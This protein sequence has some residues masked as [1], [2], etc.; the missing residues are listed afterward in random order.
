MHPCRAVGGVFLCLAVWACGGTRGPPY[1]AQ[2]PSYG[3]SAPSPR[4]QVHESRAW[5]DFNARLQSQGQQPALLDAR[6][7]AAAAALNDLRVQSLARDACDVGPG[8]TE[9]ALEW[10]GVYERPVCQRC[11][12]T[13]KS[14]VR[15]PDDVL[16]GL[17]ECVRSQPAGTALWGAHTRTES[18]RTFVSLLA[19]RRVASLDPVARFGRGAPVEL[20][21]VLPAGTFTLLTAPTQLPAVAA[22]LVP[23]GRGVFRHSV[24]P[25]AAGKNV[26]VTLVDPTGA[27]VA[28]LV[29]E[30]G[31]PR[32]HGA[33]EGML[34]PGD[35]TLP[36]LHQALR[37]SVTAV[38][39]QAGLLP[40][41]WSTVLD[42]AA[43]EEA[44]QAR[45][46]AA[47]HTQPPAP[48]TQTAA[49]S[50]GPAYRVFKVYGLGS[51]DLAR[52]L[53]GNP[54]VVHALTRPVD[55]SVGVGL[56]LLPRDGAAP[57]AVAVV[58]V[59]AEHPGALDLAAP[60][61]ATQTP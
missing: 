33:F 11:F 45:P 46:V 54:L 1:P 59:T 47:W 14:K 29:L 55:T 42:A 3:Q 56:A 9:A 32:A 15:I 31:T 4:M 60:L 28:R 40:S 12:W 48:A 49:Q 35:E 21:G 22:T 2:A 50:V 24:P 18:R 27:E 13:R 36:T 25:P 6:L 43:Q 37:Q 51:A 58:V 30:G 20:T 19:V 53:W 23:D 34:P 16:Q 17:A 41:R 8:A 44:N 52:Q 7:G 26:R 38:R 5:D 57:M 39:T 61:P 10:A